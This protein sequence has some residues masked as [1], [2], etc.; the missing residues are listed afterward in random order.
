MYQLSKCIA[1]KNC[2]HVSHCILYIEFN[3]IYCTSG[4]NV[5]T[6]LQYIKRGQEKPK[7]S[8]MTKNLGTTM[9]QSEKCCYTKCFVL[10]QTKC[11]KRPAIDHNKC[12]K[13]TVHQTESHCAALSWNKY[14]AVLTKLLRWSSGSKYGEHNCCKCT[15]TL[16]DRYICHSVL[17]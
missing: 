9:S 3:V 8:H 1:T 16:D 4:F 11:T 5:H 14:A 15:H 7:E 17:T 13:L 12:T 6:F 2:I 10:H